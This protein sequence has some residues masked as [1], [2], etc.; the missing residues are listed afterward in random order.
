ML[1]PF[2]PNRDREAARRIWRE[3]GWLD[4]GAEKDEAADRWVDAGRA[5]IAEVEGEAECMVL[6]APGTLAYLNEDLP[7]SCV[8][9][10]TTSRTAR[11]MGYLRCD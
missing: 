7:L 8:T 5:L 1:R 6:T 3:T 10:V 2:D 4:H 9:G 11:K